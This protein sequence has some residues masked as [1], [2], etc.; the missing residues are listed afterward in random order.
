MYQEGILKANLISKLYV[1]KLR[2]DFTKNRTRGR[3][4]VIIKES[5]K[6][7]EECHQQSDETHLTWVCIESIKQNGIVG[8]SVLPDII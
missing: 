7:H 2:T 3:I 8:G 1:T 4:A 5:I 6:H